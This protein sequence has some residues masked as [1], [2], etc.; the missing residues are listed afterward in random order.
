MLS[1]LARF[2]FKLALAGLTLIPSFS[3]ASD[4]CRLATN[5]VELMKAYQAT[6]PAFIDRKVEELKRRV[7]T[8]GIGWTSKGYT[9]VDQ[10]EP[11]D[12]FL[13]AD[14]K[15]TSAPYTLRMTG[16]YQ[17]YSGTISV[18]KRN[19]NGYNQTPLFSKSHSSNSEV[20][21]S[22]GTI[23]QRN[24]LMQGLIGEYLTVTFL[25]SCSKL[26]GK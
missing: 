26:Q 22:N 11:H 8:W 14:V 7:E 2:T 17:D 1:N 23:D 12:L 4:G 16:T 9:L 20:F 25:P 6:D 21:G 3:M 10:S 24:S 19:S 18:F 15:L 13:Q 5:I